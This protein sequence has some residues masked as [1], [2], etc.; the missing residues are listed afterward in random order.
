MSHAVVV[1]ALIASGCGNRYDVEFADC[2]VTCEG[3]GE[4][5]DGFSCMA[6]LCRVQGAGAECLAPGEVTLRQTENDMVE[7]NLVFGCTNPDTTTAD[8]SWYRVFSL[9]QAGITTTF[10]VTKVTLGICFA[11]GM[12]D[13][14]VRVGSYSGGANDATLDLAGIGNPVTATIPVMATQ[15]SKTVDI[16][17]TTAIPAGSNL[18]V[19]VAV[20]DLEG[21]GEQVNVGFTASNES[22]SGYVRSP[23]CG[24][25]TATNTTGAGLP[26]ARL[27]LTVT[28]TP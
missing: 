19:E 28:G 20:P 15:I 13:V 14:T 10:D 18:I 7:R 23:L 12:P 27:V 24:P 21:T 26:N 16:P 6:G 5:P 3:S 4:C 22:K 8:G 2:E 25:A 1:A 17:I 9:A 11:V